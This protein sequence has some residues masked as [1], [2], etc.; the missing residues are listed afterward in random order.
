MTHS[1]GH[2]LILNIVVTLNY[3]ITIIYFIPKENTQFVDL[4]AMTSVYPTLL[5]YRSLNFF[6]GWR[7]IFSLYLYK[8]HWANNTAVVVSFNAEKTVYYL[9]EQS[10][11]LVKIYWRDLRTKRR[12]QLRPW[13]LS[14]AFWRYHLVPTLPISWTLD[15]STK[16]IRYSYKAKTQSNY[17]ILRGILPT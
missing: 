9:L 8:G 17:D 4:F 16:L 11:I 12:P 10:I 14:E 1:F 6:L 15:W 3:Y 5:T 2:Q 7:K 13:C